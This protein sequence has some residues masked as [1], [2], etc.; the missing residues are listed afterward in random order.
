MVV[1]RKP[2]ITVYTIAMADLILGKPSVL[3]AALNSLNHA[4]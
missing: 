2:L 4:G 1:L 3:F